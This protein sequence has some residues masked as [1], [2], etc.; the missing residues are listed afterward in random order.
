[1][2]LGE[3]RIDGLS[4]RPLGRRQPTIAGLDLVVPAGQRVLLV[5]PSGAGKST[6]LMALIGALGTTLAGDLTGSV[7]VTGRA[8]LLPQNPADAVV[9]EHIGRDVAFGLE[10][11]RKPR[12]E[13]WDRV[14]A[15]LAAVGLDHGRNHFVAALS[16][17]ELQRMVLAG[18]LALQP[19]VLLLD[20]PTSML[21]R[22]SAAT[23]RQAIDA[24]IGERT[25]I[26][27]EHRFEPWL[28]HVD[29]VIALDRSGRIVSDG[30]VAEF[31]AAPAPAGVWMPGGPIPT[32]DVLPAELVRPASTLT[33]RA[34]DVDVD[35][36]TRTLRGV[37]RAA[38]VRAFSAAIEPGLI[39]ALTGPSGSGKSTALEVLGGL[40]PPNRGSVA[41]ELASLRSSEVA[42]QVGWVPQNPEIGFL[43]SSV[44]EEIALT[45]R[46]TGR[47]VDT[48][49][50]ADVFGLGALLASS[51]F[52]LSGGEQRRLA[53]AAGLAHRPAALLL[54]EPTV[55]Q[56]PSTW[57]AVTGWMTSA[58]DAGA[59]VAFA[60]HDPD[61]PRDATLEFG[62]SA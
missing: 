44:A 10:N 23:A 40:R 15:A 1:L 49:A 14:D 56:D 50:V 58:R 27:V 39:T 47:V 26:V 54:D 32:P 35:L 13:I 62:E 55:G 9:A 21:D 38:A 5:G 25:L 18:V 2:T 36:V 4:W 33:I 61:A 11:I 29:R 12:P 57:A 17:G 34:S 19:D 52:R 24:A 30:S 60:T 51:P 41:P 31:L 20:E 6:L 3:V 8:G 48:A 53:L 16:G 37:H 22:R 43:A 59:A 46:R 45:G 28:E 7:A 42:R